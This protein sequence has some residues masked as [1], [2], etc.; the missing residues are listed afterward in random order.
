LSGLDPTVLAAVAV[1]AFFAVLAIILLARYRSVSARISASSDLGKELMDSLEARLKVQ[2]ERIIDV[3]TRLEVIQTRTV[4]RAR[5]AGFHTTAP[6]QTYS[7]L[8]QLPTLAEEPR[9]EYQPQAQSQAQPR[10]VKTR[11]RRPG[12]DSAEMKALRFL[13][14]GPKTSVEIKDRTTLSREHAARVMKGLYDRGMVVRDDSH[15]PFL[16]QITDAGK[17]YLSG[18]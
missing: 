1:T 15:K 7:T 10:Q 17:N 4:E 12:A 14:E 2:D 16:Y 5:Q 8:S 6:Q 13:S 18:G 9:P 11:I 3:M